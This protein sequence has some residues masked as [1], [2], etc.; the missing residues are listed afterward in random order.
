MKPVASKGTDES[1]NRALH[2]SFGTLSP[3][4]QTSI[5]NDAFV[6]GQLQ[7]Y[8]DVTA[9]R[10][11]PARNC[12]DVEFATAELASAAKKQLKV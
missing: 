8:G 3:E 5:I 4:Q 12:F 1:S 2:V 7:Q 11:N 10:C 9:I 6:R